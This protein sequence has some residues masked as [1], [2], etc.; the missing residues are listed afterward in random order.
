MRMNTVYDLF[1]DH[2]LVDEGDLVDDAPGGGRVHNYARPPQWGHAIS[3]WSPVDTR[4]EG[5]LVSAA[6][7]G[8]GI[9]VGDF[10]A[11]RCPGTEAVA[12]YRV[13]NIHYRHC[14]DQWFATL[15]LAPLVRNDNH[16][17]KEVAE[18]KP[19]RK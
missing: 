6:G 7:F 8:V 17:R 5:L 2:R 4:K 16:D 3:W 9:G 15:E 12:R 1:N 13:L 14:S 10:L 18:R 19:V 11:L